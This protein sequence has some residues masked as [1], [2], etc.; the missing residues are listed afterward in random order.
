MT[1]ASPS[2]HLIS[3]RVMMISDRCLPPTWG[4]RWDSSTWLCL[5][6]RKR[7]LNAPSQAHIGPDPSL[8]SEFYMAPAEDSTT[9]RVHCHL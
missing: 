6:L 1:G 9:Q 8:F 2:G 4:H 7:R 3:A 5:G